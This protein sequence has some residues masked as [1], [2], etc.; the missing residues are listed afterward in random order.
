MALRPCSQAISF[1]V[2]L[3]FLRSASVGVGVSAPDRPLLA[4]SCD[5]ACF[6]AA[7]SMM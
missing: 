4:A 7:S 3:N 1:Q 2:E 6:A 5:L